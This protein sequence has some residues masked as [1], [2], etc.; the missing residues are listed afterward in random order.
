[1]QIIGKQQQSNLCGWFVLATAVCVVGMFIVLA[2]EL[3]E[4]WWRI[5]G[6]LTLAFAILASIA[7][8][9]SRTGQTMYDVIITDETLTVC[10]LMDDYTI[11][12]QDGDV[13]R[14]VMNE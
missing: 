12:G 8:F 13:L 14:V 3:S 5:F 11:L 2:F 1:M 6:T 9:T 10:E 7:Q 4:I